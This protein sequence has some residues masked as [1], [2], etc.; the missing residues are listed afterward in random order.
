MGLHYDQKLD[1]SSPYTKM[2]AKAHMRTFQIFK[3][4]STT[5]QTLLMKAYKIYV[6]PLVKSGST[7]F[8]PCKKKDKAKTETVQNSFTRKI[9]IRKGSFTYSSIPRAIIRNRYFD[10][11][12]LESRRR[13]FDVCMVYKILHEWSS[14]KAKLFFS[15]VTSITRGGEFK[16]FYR[17]PRTSVRTRS[18]TVRAGAAYLSLNKYAP[19]LNSLAAFRK[20]AFTRTTTF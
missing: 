16:I 10:I 20:F 9:F 13:F 4:L 2:C 15:I 17:R 6:R 3:A 19:P 8:S 14:E 11:P 5:D 1:F 12:S 7:V 18:F